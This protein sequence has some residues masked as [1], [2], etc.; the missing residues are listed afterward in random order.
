[1]TWRAMSARLYLGQQVLKA[2]AEVAADAHGVRPPAERVHLLDRQVVHRVV[3][4]IESSSRY[5]IV[6]DR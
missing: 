3:E 1:M 2:D 5:Y 4:P 6:T